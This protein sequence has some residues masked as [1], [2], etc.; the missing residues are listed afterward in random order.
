MA[1]HRAALRLSLYSRTNAG[2]VY[3]DL[4]FGLP[5][6]RSTGH[7]FL[8]VVYERYGGSRHDLPGISAGSVSVASSRLGTV[9]SASISYSD[10]GADQFQHGRSPTST[11]IWPGA[12]A[13]AECGAGILDINGRRGSRSAKLIQTAV[14][15]RKEMTWDR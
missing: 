7:A 15:D 1:A 13:V 9:I 4:L 12:D 11:N 3:F 8:G 14:D 5:C 6:D 2:E 10:T